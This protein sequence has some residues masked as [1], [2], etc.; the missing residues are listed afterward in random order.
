MSSTNFQQRPG[1][2]G[3]GLPMTAQLQGITPA[4]AATQPSPGAAIPPALSF[5]P[6]RPVLPQM[7]ANVLAAPGVGLPGAAGG[8]PPGVN[9]LMARQA[10]QGAPGAN[11]GILATPVI[12][13]GIPGG[14][15]TAP[16]PAMGAMPASVP[17]MT[18]GEWQAAMAQGYPA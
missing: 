7:P 14:Q 6:A 10:P 1:W 11:A 9:A 13:A 4:L 3:T 17:G 8:V 16:T 18:A 5:A 2:Q 12:P 15:A